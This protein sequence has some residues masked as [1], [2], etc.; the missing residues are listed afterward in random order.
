M[1]GIVI[2]GGGTGGHISPAIAVSESISAIAPDQSVDFIGSRRPVDLRM[3]SRFGSRFHALDPPRMDRGAADILLL[4]FRAVPAYFTARRLLRE[5]KA[6]A[7]L[8]TGGYPS[9]FPC[10]AANHLGIP[11]FVHESNS[12]PGRANRM[13]AR[14]ATTI[15]TG[16]RSA[17]SGFSRTV[18]HTGNP[19]RSSLRR[20]PRMDAMAALGLPTEA[21]CILFL[22]GSQGAGALNDMA[23]EAPAGMSVL[24]Q[25]GTRDE[26]RV[27]AAAAGR[28][29]IFVTGFMDDPSPLYSA[30]DIAVARAGSMTIAELSWFRLPSVLVPYPFAADGHQLTNAS[31]IT[32]EGGAILMEQDGLEASVLWSALASL[33]ANG[34]RRRSMQEAL[35]R[36]MP[37]NPADMI[38]GLVL[39]AAGYPLVCPERSE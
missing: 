14:F 16:F 26:E 27:R 18:I 3:Y 4:P 36:I 17:G 19:V 28:E 8:S 23:L 25:C 7:L 5:L 6:S 30:A 1:N 15:L 32:S 37:G 39:E 38:A 29:G 12:I 21:P 2:A 33:A 22:G 34:E 11:V 13:A 31:E 9:F 35:E 20:I 10:L 24:L